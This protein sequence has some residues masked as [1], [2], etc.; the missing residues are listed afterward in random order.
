M[1]T[2]DD[3]V[4]IYGD[5]PPSR[6]RFGRSYFG[7][8]PY[9]QCDCGAVFVLFTDDGDLMHDCPL[10]DPTLRCDRCGDHVPDGHGHYV[11]GDDSTRLCREC[12]TRETDGE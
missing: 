8:Q 1:I 4:N 10:D 6:F 11:E 5:M 3:T 7:G 12:F 9:A 2:D